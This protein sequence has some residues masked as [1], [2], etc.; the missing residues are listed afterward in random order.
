M[1]EKKFVGKVLDRSSC[2]MVDPAG[3]RLAEVDST[4]IRWI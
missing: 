1:G 3:D 4:G 2:V